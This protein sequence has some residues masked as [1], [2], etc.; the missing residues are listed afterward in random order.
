MTGMEPREQARDAGEQCR[1]DL[2]AGVD[3]VLKPYIA[4]KKEAAPDE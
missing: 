4:A 1:A 3:E 2:D